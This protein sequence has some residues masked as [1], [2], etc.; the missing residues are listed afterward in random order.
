[1]FVLIQEKLLFDLR[2]LN[3]VAVAFGLTQIKK[4]IQ[5]RRRKKLLKLKV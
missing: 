4:K 5:K 3:K 1:M 2:G